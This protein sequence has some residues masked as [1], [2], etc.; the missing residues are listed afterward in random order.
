MIISAAIK[1]NGK[2]YFG[3]WHGEA[4]NNAGAIGKRDNDTTFG[5]LTDGGQF[6]NRR[7][8]Y[9]HAVE[10]CQKID[11]GKTNDFCLVMDSVFLCDCD[12]NPQLAKDICDQKNAAP[13][14]RLDTAHHQKAQPQPSYAHIIKHFHKDS[15][16]GLHGEINDEQGR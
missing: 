14:E 10:C 1:R 9:L 6:L 11:L 16:D 12:Y 8:A 3:R 2:Y 5:F 4:L 15:L 7:M 13:K